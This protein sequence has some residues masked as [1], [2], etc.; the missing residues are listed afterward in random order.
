MTAG[1]FDSGP[2]NGG[3]ARIEIKVTPLPGFAIA[4][5]HGSGYVAG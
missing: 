5:M 1:D 2:G 4:K 3:S